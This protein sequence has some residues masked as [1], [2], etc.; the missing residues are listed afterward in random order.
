MTDWLADWMTQWLRSW[1][2]D[3]LSDWVTDWQDEWLSDWI[4]EW[5]N[6]WVT[7][8]LMEGDSPDIWDQ[9]YSTYLCW[10]Q[11]FSSAPCSV[12][13]LC[14]DPCSSLAFP[15]LEKPLS[16]FLILVVLSLPGL[17][18]SMFPSAEGCL[19]S[20][21][22]LG[23]GILSSVVPFLPYLEDLVFLA[24]AD[25]GSL[26]P[27]PARSDLCYWTQNETML[28]FV[29]VVIQNNTLIKQK[30]II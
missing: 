4:T 19:G 29:A 10:I 8:Y 16:H 18:A 21:T 13:P 25:G 11:P 14:W 17:V 26:A 24:T 5:V 28:Y 7:D 1:V 12:L 22:P 6:E 15:F 2:S 9:S 27:D 3:L 23:L 20:E 30:I